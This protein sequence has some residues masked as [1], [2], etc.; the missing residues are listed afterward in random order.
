MKNFKEEI[1]KMYERLRSGSCF[2]FSKYADGEWKAMQGFP[3][4]NQEFEC[5]REHKFL[6]S[7]EK[8][9]KSFKYKDSNYYVGISCP[10]CGGDEHQRMK[11]YSEQPEENLTFANIFVNSN[12]AFYKENFLKEYAKRDI[13]LVANEN[14]KVDNLPFSVEKFY[15]IG[16]SAWVNNSGLVEEIAK[17]ELE[18]KLVLFCAGPFGN[19]LA[20]QLWEANKNNTYLDVGST[21]NPWLESEGFRRGYY[22][23]T[24]R[25]KQDCIWG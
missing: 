13:H 10:C 15:P 21:L 6:D 23:E 19:I 9:Q 16:F 11:E 8:L 25:A 3:M 14:S 12:Y 2:S 7:I 22:M 24:Y 1:E 17:S 5:S 18:G 20:Q 4:N